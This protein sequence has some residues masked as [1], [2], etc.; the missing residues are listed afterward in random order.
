MRR[1]LTFLT[2]GLAALLVAAPAQAALDEGG[3][4]APTPV[5][6]SAAGFA[7]SANA[8]PA[9]RSDAVTAWNANAGEAAI[10]ACISPVNNPLHES[11]LYAM[12]HVAIHDAL[13]AIDR[14]SRPYAFSARVKRGASPEAAVAA[15]AE[16]VR[17]GAG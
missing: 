6:S 8:H 13:N 2:V 7:A 17:N 15:A 9:A 16:C 10:A 4:A 14:R 11:H 12:T 1:K 3:G 5:V